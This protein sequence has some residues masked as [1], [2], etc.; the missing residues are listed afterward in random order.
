MR[1]GGRA[2]EGG[3]C[4]PWDWSPPPECLCAYKGFV[5]AYNQSKD[6]FLGLHIHRCIFRCE[7]LFD[8]NDDGKSV[9]LPLK[10]SQHACC[11]ITDSLLSLE[12]ALL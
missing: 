4:S 12:K 6:I 11:L 1:G 10:H 3:L 8:G 2:V 9:E 7:F 5:F